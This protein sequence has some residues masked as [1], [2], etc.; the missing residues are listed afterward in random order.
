[1]VESIVI[2]ALGLA[3]FF[4]ALYLRS[5]KARK[6][7]AFTCPLKGNCTEVIHSSY[8][9]FL[10]LPVELLGT[11]YYLLIAVG[12][13]ARV[14]FPAETLTLAFPLLMVSTLALLF[15]SYLTF[16]QV[17]RLRKLCTWCLLSAAFCL[18]IFLLAAQ[19]NPV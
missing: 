12:Y 10:S 1:M 19:L 3:G 5:K 7:T 17:V 14:G 9:T 15:S 11:A 6:A 2:V 13:G 18:S 8:A 16:I 4:L